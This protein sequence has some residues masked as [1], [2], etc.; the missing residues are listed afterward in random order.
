[1]AR[2]GAVKPLARIRELR[3]PKAERKAARAA[4]RNLAD[5]DA[6]SRAAVAAESHSRHSG[7]WS[8]TWKSD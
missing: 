1:M 5:A 6:A 2:R 4:R 8:G 7:G 3:L